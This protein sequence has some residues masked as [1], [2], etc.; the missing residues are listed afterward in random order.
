MNY[1]EKIVQ[2]RKKKNITQ[3]NIADHLKITQQQY[4]AYEKGKNE[5]PIRY[6][7]EICI[8]LDISADWLLGL[9]DEP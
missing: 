3:K 7:T 6:F 9:K 1:L 8:Y 5:M 4:Q 2:I